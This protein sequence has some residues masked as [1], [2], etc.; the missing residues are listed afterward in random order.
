MD[1]NKKYFNAIVII[2]FIYFFVVQIYVSEINLDSNFHNF[3][4]FDN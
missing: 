1:F 4:G 2:Q 3:D